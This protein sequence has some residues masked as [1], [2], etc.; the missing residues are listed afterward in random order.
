MST[1]TAPTRP[2]RAKLP[3]RRPVRPA[4]LWALRAP[5]T[6]RARIVLIICSVLVPL[7]AWVAVA[8]SGA[9]PEQFLPSPS[10][11]LAAG[12]EMA[13][14]GQLWTDTWASVQ[15]ILIGFGLAIVV[16]VPLGLV[17]GSFQAGQALF[18]PLVGLLRYLPASAFIPL[19]TIWLGI[20]EPSKWMLLFIGTVFFNTLM[21]ADAV[22]QVPRALIDVSYTLGAR[23]GEVLRKV[24][25]PHAL[26]GMI[27]AVR[28]NA[29][30]AWNF[31]VVAELINSQEGLG[32]RIARSQRFLASD[33][34]FAILIVIAVIGLALDIALRVLRDRIGRWV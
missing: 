20:G 19:L 25:V 5:I 22:R 10:A 14:S 15:R 8:A 17:M 32:Y 11:V 9:V 2:A 18:E 4:R 27:D 31:V 16:S 21:T 28:V 29:A 26:P 6:R 34:I 12:W 24:V 23:R 13:Q 7:V 30:A 1:V 33:R 3:R